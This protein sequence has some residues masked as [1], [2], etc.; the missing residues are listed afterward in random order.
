MANKGPRRHQKRLS[1]PTVQNLAV[2]DF[3][4]SMMNKP[5][6]HEKAWSMP[7][8]ILLR[9]KLE[10]S[11]SQKENRMVL[12]NGHVKVNGVIRKSPRFGVGLFDVVSLGEKDAHR[13]V[14]DEKG[15]FIV[16][17]VKTAGMT[18]AKVKFKK[19]VK[20]GKVALT[21]TNGLT[22]EEKKSDVK[23][24]DSVVIQLDKMQMSDSLPLATG[25]TVLLLGGKHVGSTAVIESMVDS[26]WHKPKLLTLKSGK[27]TFQTTSGSVMVIGK[28]KI[29]LAEI[30]VNA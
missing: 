3:T 27:S 12:N 7:L 25:S 10:V 4:F 15:R 20:G 8:G 24:G 16:V 26:T 13:L 2:K 17:P 14:I 6:A 28:P 5:G 22:L 18:V 9:D 23:V 21:L 29:V 19:M 30:G 1:S 11:K